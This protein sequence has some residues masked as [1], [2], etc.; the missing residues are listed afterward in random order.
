MKKTILLF[1]GLLLASITQAQI[2]LNSSGYPTSVLGTDS[3][4]TLI[5]TTS[6]PFPS[7]VAATNG[8]WDLSTMPDSGLSYAYR[9]NPDTSA[10]QFAD[11]NTYSFSTY[12]YQGNL[13]AAITS[14]GLIEYGA[15]IPTTTFTLT[16]GSITVPTQHAVF[17]SPYTVIK[18]PATMS[19]TWSSNYES[20]FNFL[21]SYTV[22][23]FPVYTNAPGV[24]K[25]FI[26]ETDSVKGWG[27]MRVPGF[28]GGASSWFNVLQVQTTTTVMD[29]FLINGSVPPSAV[30]TALGV[31]E[32]QTTN[33][34]QQSY[35]RTGEVTPFAK[36]Q[37]PDATFS[38]PSRG[39]TNS[40]RLINTGIAN[41]VNNSGV[42]IYPNPVTGNEVTID[43]P[44]A[45]GAWSY[46]LIDMSGRNV[47]SG[48]LQTNGNHAQLSIPSVVTPGIYYIRI[49]NNGNQICVRSIDI[50]K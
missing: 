28:T 22:G 45:G 50:A 41:V 31:T 48:S 35:Y 23:G 12:S 26:T 49:N 2:T 34:Y 16:S 29:S 43:L 7:L 33:T 10:A 36:I 3:L 24:V 46:E 1:A 17:S 25:S 38:A 44:A 6:F 37:Y 9:V 32:G 13:Q 18:F 11:S 42:N 19:S 27:K 39:T 30:L 4:M 14:T 15:D 21:V 8:S 5:P 47:T 20:D 40:Q